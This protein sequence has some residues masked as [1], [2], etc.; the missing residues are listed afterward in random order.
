M[1]H[2]SPLICKCTCFHNWTAV[3]LSWVQYLSQANTSLCL[4]GKKWNCSFMSVSEIPMLYEI[5]VRGRR[6][7]SKSWLRERDSANISKLPSDHFS[8]VVCLQ[9]FKDTPQKSLMGKNPFKKGNS[10]VAISF[11][12]ERQC[13]ISLIG[14]KKSRFDN[15]QFLYLFCYYCITFYKA[16]PFSVISYQYVPNNSMGAWDGIY[17]V[18][19]VFLYQFSLPLRR[20][21]Q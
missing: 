20:Y 7:Q 3:E 16:L 14:E 18:F 2:P 8:A 19:T 21:W 11:G 10:V 4:E 12:R 9:H 1:E 5:T 15:K 13:S 6:K 17:C